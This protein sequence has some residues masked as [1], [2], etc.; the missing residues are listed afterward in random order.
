M[1]I[2]CGT[3]HSDRTVV[4][5]LHKHFSSWISTLCVSAFSRIEH[6]LLWANV[7][8]TL[9]VNNFFHLLEV[10]LLHTGCLS[11]DFYLDCTR[12]CKFMFLTHFNNKS[13]CFWRRNYISPVIISPMYS[14]HIHDWWYNSDV[15]F[16]WPPTQGNI[17]HRL[18]MPNRDKPKIIT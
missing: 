17:G 11:P 2:V 10:S 18:Y 1:S 14:I 16:C 15:T 13:Q 4:V 12:W 5:L 3:V 6:L 7:T 8:L 9:Y